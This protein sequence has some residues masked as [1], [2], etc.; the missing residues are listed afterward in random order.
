MSTAIVPQATSELAARTVPRDWPSDWSLADLQQHLGG[1][2]A[3][4]IRL[5]PAPGCATEQDLVEIA[6]HEDR[7][8][9]LDDG[10]LV[11]KSTGW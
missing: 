5:V 11:E 3:E 10:V 6:V 9:E 4:R 7:L 8:Y 1:I 2:P